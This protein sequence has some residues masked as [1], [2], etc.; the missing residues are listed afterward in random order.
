MPP[1]GPN[2]PIFSS[3]WC[4]RPEGTGHLKHMVPCEGRSELMGDLAL[5]LPQKKVGR[6]DER[7]PQIMG[8]SRWCVRRVQGLKHLRDHRDTHSFENSTHRG[9]V[10]PRGKRRGGG[11]QGGP[12]PR[13]AAHESFQGSL[14]SG[15]HALRC[16]EASPSRGPGIVGLLGPSEI[17]SLQ[18]HVGYKRGLRE[19]EAGCCQRCCRAAATAAAAI[20]TPAATTAA[21]AAVA[22]AGDAAVAHMCQAR[23]ESAMRPPPSGAVRH[24]H[25]QDPSSAA[26][27]ALLPNTQLDH[28]RHSACGQ[29]VGIG[30]REHDENREDNSKTEGCQGCGM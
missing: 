14:I 11:H 7:V 26:C 29:G 20:S 2:N 22:G 6:Q 13:V 27:A 17:G 24:H 3:R 12:A 30:G 10:A 1:Q 5:A 16:S 4:R 18:G 19:S 28:G 9:Q 8:A 25:S 15:G 23:S 21:A